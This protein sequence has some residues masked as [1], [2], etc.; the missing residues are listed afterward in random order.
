MFDS[1]FILDSLEKFLSVSQV[2]TDKVINTVKIVVRFRKTP[3]KFLSY[4]N[5]KI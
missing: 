5:S 1:G 4:M 2:I 3:N